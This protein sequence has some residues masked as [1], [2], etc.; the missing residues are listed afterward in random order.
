MVI[1]GITIDKAAVFAFFQEPQVQT[2]LRTFIAAPSGFVAVKLAHWLGL[3]TDQLGMVA[4]YAIYAAP[5]LVVWVFAMAQ[6][7]HAAII[8]EAGRQLA[9]M[10]GG[11]IVVSANATDAVKAMASN[12]DHPG[13][14][15][16]GTDAA[17]QAAA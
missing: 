4:T 1:A 13:V 8:A 5:Y 15:T 7:T 11:K 3:N 6:R 2:T 14:V 10:Q 17:K 16:A 12:D 9:K